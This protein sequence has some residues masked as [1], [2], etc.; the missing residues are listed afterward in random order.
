MPESSPTHRRALVTGA[1]GFLGRSL[2]RRLSEDGWDVHAIV[3]PSSRTEALGE[4]LQEVHVDDGLKPLHEIVA[5]AAPTV[6]FHLAGY[7]IGT[8]SDADIA[9]LVTDNVLFGTRLADALATL[10]DCR[11]VNAGS[12]WQNAGGS[13][14][15]PVALYAATKQALQDILQYYV[16]SGRLEVVTLKFFETYG[17]ADDR[18]KLLNLLL[19]AAANHQPIGVSPGHQLIDLV[20][21]DDAISACVAAAVLPSET[22]PSPPPSYAVT[23]GAPLQLRELVDRIGAIIGSDVPVEWSRR[24]YRWREM[25]DPWDVGPV[26]PGWAPRVSLEEGVAELWRS[27]QGPAISDGAVN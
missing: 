9:P 16:E 10:G 20:H 17:P 15:H 24:E 3:R 27:F 1:S 5:A 18:P 6:C 22:T 12:Y 25:M 19:R 8:H 7:F 23:S 14:Y 13:S 26:V 21:V 4:W 11:M 2:V